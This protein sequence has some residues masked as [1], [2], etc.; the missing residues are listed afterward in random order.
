MSS[1]KIAD[2]V[3]SQN[4]AILANIFGVIFIQSKYTIGV[5]IIHL[6]HVLFNQM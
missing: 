6:K 2:E 1:L 5:S 4:L 3:L